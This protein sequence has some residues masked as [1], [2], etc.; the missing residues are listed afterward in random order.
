MGETLQKKLKF[1]SDQ[2]HKVQLIWLV[3]PIKHLDL[4]DY[5]MSFI[6]SSLGGQKYHRIELASETRDYL[7]I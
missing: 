2:S 7:Q 6:M 5:F 3:S 4:R 1:L